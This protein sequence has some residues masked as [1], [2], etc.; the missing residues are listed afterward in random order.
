MTNN[1]SNEKFNNGTFQ[2]FIQRDNQG[3]SSYIQLKNNYP[4][5]ENDSFIYQTPEQRNKK[6]KHSKLTVAFQTLGVVGAVAVIGFSVNKSKIISNQ[7]KKWALDFKIKYSDVRNK[8]LHK[9][10]ALATGAFDR[11]ARVITNT[12]TI[13]DYSVHK[14]LGKTETTRKFRDNVARWFTNQNKSSVIAAIKKSRESNIEFTSAVSSA[15]NKTEEAIA[16]G[17]LNILNPKYREN[18]DS[19]DHPLI[20][21]RNFMDRLEK[22]SHPFLR[23]DNVEKHF[24][25]M[26]KDMAYLSEQMHPKRLISKEAAQGFVAEDILEE[27]RMNFVKVILDEK[28]DVSNTFDDIANY[29]KDRISDT[30][31]LIYQ[32]KDPNMQK[33]LREASVEFEKCVK[34]YAKDAH[35]SS[36]RPAVTRNVQKKIAVLREKAERLP[37]NKSKE[38]LLH[39]IKEYEDMFKSDTKGIVQE[40]RELAGQIWGKDSEFDKNIKK[41][42]NVHI[43]DL[44]KSFSCLVNMF[45]KQRDITLGSGAADLISL[46][47]PVITYLIALSK[48]DTKEKKVG[49]SLELGIPILG[50]A[51]V[52]AY[53]LVEQLN[54][55]KALAV[56]VGVGAILNL[57]GSTIYKQY[58]YHRAI[59]NEKNAHENAIIAQ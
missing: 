54:G 46:T 39:H 53:S 30:N 26:Q 44:N 17:N 37:D 48:D 12:S 57:I 27:R 52:Y 14:I 31:A 43:K 25:S 42:A 56:S 10:I 9:F 2:P 59:E 55:F 32:F 35:T 4:T 11:M 33:E 51:G 29:A 38:K 3:Y 15:I 47:V 50:G 40:I 8:H 22:Q 1:I 18:I 21:L 36:D 6:R 16:S 7:L 41:A 19:F 20:K 34:T 23:T 45:D 13:K 5:Q 49:T 24:N 28:N 58:K